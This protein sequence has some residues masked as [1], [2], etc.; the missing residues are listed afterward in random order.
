MR[1]LHMFA[2]IGGGLLAD[3][4]L[5]HTPIA[6]VE[7][8]AYCCAVLRERAAEGWYPG[9]EIIEADVRGVDFR[10]FA[11]RVD[12]LSAGFPCQ[13][14]S[15]AGRGAGITGERSGLVREVF[16]AIAEC[17][18]GLVFIENVPAIERRGRREVTGW[19]VEAGYCWRD[20]TI[21]AADVGAPH[22]RQRWFCLAAN[23]DGM[24]ELEQ[25]RRKR[26]ERRWTSDCIEQIDADVNPGGWRSSQRIHDER[27]T[28]TRTSPYVPDNDSERLAVG[29][30]APRDVYDGYIKARRTVET[31]TGIRHWNAAHDA[32]FLR[33]VHGNA[34][35]LHVRDRIKALGNSQV[36]LQAAAAFAILA[37]WQ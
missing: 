1:T 22:L 11:S 35:L 24:R 34:A 20:G 29:K 32:D 18:P 6:A 15:A 2:G 30:A 17:K 5:G 31:Q 33:V 10:R 37:G 19:L 28:T 12:C 9:L 3:L 8:D 4:I 36:P 14:I 21:A 13:D 23:A 27:E 16:R 25:E 26:N 7:L